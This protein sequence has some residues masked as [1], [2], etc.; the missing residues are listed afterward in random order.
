MNILCQ[1]LG[2]KL[3]TFIE[4]EY[5]NKITKKEVRVCARCGKTCGN[6]ENDNATKM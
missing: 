5:K 6:K 4:I 2:H 3:E 1:L